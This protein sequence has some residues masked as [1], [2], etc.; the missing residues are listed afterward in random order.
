MDNYQPIHY[1]AC[2]IDWLESQISDESLAVTLTESD[3]HILAEASDQIEVERLK[4]HLEIARANYRIEAEKNKNLRDVC[5]EYD[6]ELRSCAWLIVVLFCVALVATTAAIHYA[7][8][9]M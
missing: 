4:R 7:K 2:D 6:F 8:V 1:M 3:L 5:E 9:G